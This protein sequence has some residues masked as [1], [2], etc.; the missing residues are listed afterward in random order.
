MTNPAMWLVLFP[1]VTGSLAVVILLWQGASVERTLD[2]ETHRFVCTTL[3]R[4]VV[5]TLLRSR[6]SGKVVGIQ[7]C[8]GFFDTDRATCGAECLAGFGKTG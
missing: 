3:H 2:V 8:M 1:I 4:E 5:A 7:S 6:S